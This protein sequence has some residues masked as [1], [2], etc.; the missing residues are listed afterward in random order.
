[1]GLILTLLM[2]VAAQSGSAPVP[3]RAVAEGV[4][5]YQRGDFAAAL[6]ILKP[7][8]YDVPPDYRTPP[9]PWAAAYLAQMFRRGQGTTPD[10]PLSCALFNEVWS[11][12]RQ[13]G[14]AGI[15]MIPFVEDGIQ[16]V[17][18][19]GLQ[20]EVL[21]LRQAPYLD[22]V[23]RW[24]FVFDGRSS[25][26]VD[27]LGFHIDLD[28]E[29]RDL[30]FM[31][32][33][34][35][36]T[37]VSLTE[38]DVSVPDR[39][40]TGRVHFLELFK[41]ANRFDQTKNVIV[42]ELHWVLYFVRGIDGGPVTDQIVV[43]VTGGPYPSHELPSGIR[44]AVALRLN[45][46]GR[47]EWSVAGA[48]AKRGIL[49]EPG[50]QEVSTPQTA[51]GRQMEEPAPDFAVRFDHKGCHYEYLDMF[52]GTYSG[53]GSGPVAFSL[54]KEQRTTLF[55]AIVAARLFELPVTVDAAGGEPADNYVLEIRNAGRRQT[56]S[57]NV[58]SADRSLSALTRTMLSMLN[59][60][61]GDGCVGGLPKV[62]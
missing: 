55:K 50:R 49:P 6:S 16:E 28:G 11:Y 48:T 59:P 18:L 15:G 17:C 8:I 29:H 7:I 30:P 1:M 46:A 37:V 12:T 47:V 54:S 36:E 9:N 19:P 21:A 61:P 31:L 57:W 35:H 24:G 34:G 38:A 2:V 5:A 51:S 41:W 10:W 13:R 27:R 20:P 43:T 40:S 25:L 45:D 53:G 22:G 39:W 26:I 23:T 32:I 3:D 44:E 4:A 56:L 52:K 14:P 62:R 58:A 60:H 33:R 42:R